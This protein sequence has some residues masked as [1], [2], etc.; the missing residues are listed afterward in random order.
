MDLS[1]RRDSGTGSYPVITNAPNGD[2]KL[3]LVYDMDG[4]ASGKADVEFR[5]QGRTQCFLQ[6]CDVSENASAFVYDARFW[7]MPPS[8]IRPGTS[9][10]VTLPAPWELGASRS[11]NCDGAICRSSEWNDHVEKGRGRRRS[12]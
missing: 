9:W 7:G 5:D 4:I 2:L 10:E 12:V 6:K 1:V 3:S 11:S 8:S